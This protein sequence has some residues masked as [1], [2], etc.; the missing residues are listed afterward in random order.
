[1]RLRKTFPTNYMLFLPTITYLHLSSERNF[2]EK[3]IKNTIHGDTYVFHKH[4]LPINSYFRTML[5][6]TSMLQI[7]ALLQG[8]LKTFNDIAEQ[9][10]ILRHE[11]KIYNQDS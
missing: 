11:W 10:K 2:S 3:Q 4:H 6:T 1:M 7:R 5:W 8:Q 9:K